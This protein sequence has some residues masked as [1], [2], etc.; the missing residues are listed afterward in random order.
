MACTTLQFT[1]MSFF[2][3]QCGPHLKSRFLVALFALPKPFSFVKGF[4]FANLGVLAYLHFISS[5]CLD[6][7]PMLENRDNFSI[8]V[9]WMV[10]IRW[11]IVG[12]LIS[13]DT[14]CEF[15]PMDNFGSNRA[16]TL[17]GCCSCWAS[18]LKYFA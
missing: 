4:L 11:Y 17:M 10:H 9:L 15:G 8:L 7:Q 12:L 18:F 13:Y 6:F 16:S 2:S 14:S 3:L 5:E 1:I